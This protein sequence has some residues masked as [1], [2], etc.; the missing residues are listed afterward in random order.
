MAGLTPSARRPS[1]HEA[2]S[3]YIVRRYFV[4][5]VFTP[6]G[7]RSSRGLKPAFALRTRAE[8]RDYSP[9]FIFSRNVIT[10]PIKVHT[11]SVRSAKAKLSIAL[12]TTPTR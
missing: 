5:G 2:L 12:R 3:N 8:A 1:T 9:L 11:A 4:Q 6:A 7:D 10:P